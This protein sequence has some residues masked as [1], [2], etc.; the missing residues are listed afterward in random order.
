MKNSYSSVLALGFILILVPIF[1]LK[2]F[3]SQSCMALYSGD[4]GVNGKI[5]GLQT[6]SKE[7]G[8]GGCPKFVIYPASQDLLYV[9][10]EC[11]N[12]SIAEYDDMAMDYIS[13]FYVR[14]L[15]AKG[16]EYKVSG[17]IKEFRAIKGIG[18][19]IKTLYKLGSY[20]SEENRLKN[21]ILYSI[22]S[23]IIILAAICLMHYKKK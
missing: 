9:K 2:Y 21:L 11:A 13:S 6:L 5:V 16:Y 23:S 7:H 22:V 1:S 3:S 12:K 4:A 8:L 19:D 14:D 17:E 15:T 20:C 10:F 18:V